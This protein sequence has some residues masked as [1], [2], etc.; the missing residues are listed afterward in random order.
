MSNFDNDITRALTETHF[1]DKLRADEFAVPNDLLGLCHQREVLRVV[2]ERVMMLVR[3][4]ND[5]LGDASGISQLY[6]DHLRQLEKKLYPG[7]TKLL[8]STRPSII[9]RF[10][11]VNEWQKFETVISSLLLSPFYLM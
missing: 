11:Q 1:W 9:E 6:S 4:F 10:V 5:L 8:W 7:F 2:R 3:A